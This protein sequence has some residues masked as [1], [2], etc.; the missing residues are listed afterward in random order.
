VSARL[1]LEQGIAV[2]FCMLVICGGVLFL[3]RT[4]A[5]IGSDEE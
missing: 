3:W 4:F 5:G 1:L 2:S